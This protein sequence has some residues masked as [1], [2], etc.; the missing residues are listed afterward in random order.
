MA[1]NVAVAEPTLTGRVTAAWPSFALTA[2]WELLT[3]QIRSSAPA[4]DSQA[5]REVGDGKGLAAGL[6]LR[7]GMLLPGSGDGSARPR[8]LQR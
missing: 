2:S 7:D 8:D 6:N 5:P 4:N 3:R 1:A